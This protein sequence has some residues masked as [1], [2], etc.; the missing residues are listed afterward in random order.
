[1]TPKVHKT[2]SKSYKYQATIIPRMRGEVVDSLVESRTKSKFDSVGAI[3]LG[4]H[5]ENI[6]SVRIEEID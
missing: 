4:D 1:V 2:I 6:C 5:M 3:E